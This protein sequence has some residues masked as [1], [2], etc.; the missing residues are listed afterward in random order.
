MP[1]DDRPPAGT[2]S[3]SARPAPHPRPM[4]PPVLR[5]GA[6]R[7]DAPASSADPSP[8]RRRGL[9]DGRRTALVFGVA[10]VIAAV[11]YWPA[12]ERKQNLPDALYGLPVALTVL[13]AVVDSWLSR[14][15]FT[16]ALWVA[17]GVLPAAVFARALHDVLLV[18]PTSHNLWPFEIAIAFGVSLPAALAGSAAGWLLLRA[19]GRH[20]ASAP[21]DRPHR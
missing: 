1:V 15:P 19:T 13:A 18:D 20:R 12:M 14:R 21:E 16:R 5:A 17:A 7:A 3:P 2:P 4:R 8:P 10:F 11:L 6:P 9:T